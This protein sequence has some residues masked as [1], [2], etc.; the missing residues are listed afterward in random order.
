VGAL[1]PSV[2]AQYAVLAL[3]LAAPVLL[4]GWR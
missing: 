1:L 3:L 4:G 2:L